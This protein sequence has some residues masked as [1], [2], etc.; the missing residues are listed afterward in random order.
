MPEGNLVMFVVISQ[1]M[2]VCCGSPVSNLEWRGAKNATCLNVPS[3]S[4]FLPPIIDAEFPHDSC[5]N[6]CFLNLIH[7]FLTG[8][9][10]QVSF[11]CFPSFLIVSSLSF[12]FLLKHYSAKYVVQLHIIREL[13]RGTICSAYPSMGF[14]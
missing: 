12:G 11:F 3:I 7:H 13:F 4:W 2:K 9:A 6:Q 10:L 5:F 14:V 8:D 1:L